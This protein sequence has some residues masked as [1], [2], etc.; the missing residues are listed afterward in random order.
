MGTRFPAPYRVTNDLGMPG[1]CNVQTGKVLAKPGW[2]VTRLQGGA[3]WEGLGRELTCPEPVLS[4]HGV[5]AGLVLVL[6]LVLA[7]FGLRGLPAQVW[8]KEIPKWEVLC[9][10]VYTFVKETIRNSC[11]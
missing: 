9:S 1:T 6:A 10:F 8:R 5:R 3:G 11:I 2:L 4:S 7:S